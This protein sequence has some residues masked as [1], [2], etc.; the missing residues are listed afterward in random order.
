MEIKLDASAE[1]S[2]Q[3]IAE[4]FAQEEPY[5]VGG[6]GL[7]QVDT[8]GSS[9]IEVF[10][11][12]PEPMTIARGQVIGAAENVS[13]QNMTHFQADMVNSIIEKQWRESKSYVK[14]VTIS[15]EFRKL[16]KLCK[17]EVPAKYEQKAAA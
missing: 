5:L 16:I 17:L 2:E 15:E 13:G 8:L 1:N 11:T 12:G 10:N 6:P 7:I 9:L 3:V 14:G 4:I